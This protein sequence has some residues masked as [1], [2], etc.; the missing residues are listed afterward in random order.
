MKSFAKTCLSVF[1]VLFL[2][3]IFLK[4]S[5]DEN[6]KPPGPNPNTPSAVIPDEK[7]LVVLEECRKKMEDLNNVRKLA[8]QVQFISWL[9]QKSEFQSA[10]LLE[11]GG[12]YAVFTDG[13]IIMFVDTPKTEDSFDG[14]RKRTANDKGSRVNAISR[15]KELPKS[16]K[17]SL[18]NGM[19][20][21]FEDNTLAIEKIFKSSKSA[22]AYSIE[23]KEGS[24]ENLKQV[25]G[26]GVFYFYTHG[27]SGNIPILKNGNV[28]IIYVPS[29]W[30]TIPVTGD[31]ER[32]YRTYLDEK[33][34]SYMLSTFEEENPVLHYGITDE[35]IKAHWSF[36]ENAL[37]YM[38]AC[39]S[40]Y[41]SDKGQAFRDLIKNRASNKK[42]TYIGWSQITN[43]FHATRASQ[44]IFDRLLG[45]NTT[46]SG[47]TTIPKE[48]PIQRPFDLDKIFS[49][50]INRGYHY[51]DANGA[52]LE[53]ET[54]VDD[55]I[56]L[57]PNIE[58]LEVSE[59]TSVLMIYGSFGS[60]MGK[61]TIDG[62][63]VVLI[64]NWSSSFISCVIEE[65]GEGS[66]GNVIVSVRELQSNSVP[67][68]FWD[69]KLN[70]SS[71]DNGIKM[72]GVINLKLR[73]DI[74]PRRT[75]PGGDPSLPE[76][77]DL[78]PSSG[79]TFA[80]TSSAT[81]HISGQ[82]YAK[83]NWVP[84]ANTFEETPLVRTGTAP[85]V[86]L[87]STG[88]QPNLLALYNWT[89]DRKTLKLDILNV[90]LPDITQTTYHTLYDCPENDEETRNSVLTSMNFTLPSYEINDIIKLEIADNYNIRSGS[91]SKTISRPWNPCDNSGTFEM[92]VT[93]EL[94]RPKFAPTDETPARKRMPDGK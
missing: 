61:V 80:N 10:G 58:R 90:D 21:Y 52:T 7:R 39:E 20:K 65:E 67:L 15:S 59:Y 47:S 36:A 94:I 76:F 28:E 11:G 87:G 74:H 92:S 9:L 51:W 42:A 13:R 54:S 83:C 19:G 3:W 71:N 82:K 22:S 57:T 48:D 44:Y 23:R 31:N 77:E 53:Y 60:E 30:T 12:A 27:S 16:N 1:A 4:C 66:A 32:N 29:F 8:D 69:I 49:D 63:D 45:T 33:K 46:G 35:F 17:V 64:T 38:D 84:C 41:N 24:I 40:F 43:Q 93:W 85:Y 70:Y 50:L 62:K 72:E 18:F 86:E 75:M 81:Y 2:G 6:I 78:A 89:T 5:S 91:Y 14:G 55:E 68:T 26:A 79:F 37:I 73:S 25:S 34:L 88:K 56:I